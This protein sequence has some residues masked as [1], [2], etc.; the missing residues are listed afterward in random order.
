MIRD[1][2]PV[3]VQV[4]SGFIIVGKM[5]AAFGIAVAF[6]G[7]VTIARNLSPRYEHQTELGWLLIM[8]SIVIMFTTVRFWAAG[9]CG[10]VGYAALR[11]LVVVLFADAL[12]VSR[13]YIAAMSASIIAVFLLSIRFTS[14]KWKITP[15][16][17]ISIVIAAC[18]VL[19]FF[20]LSNSYQALLVFNIGS[21]ALLASRIGAR[22]ANQHQH[23]K[24]T[25]VPG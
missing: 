6:M 3:G 20:Q 9:F 15:L 12:H 24:H 19:I 21:V 8:L 18:S 2:R 1:R 7:G 10:F 11:S 17:R 4:K 14:K 23:T 25:E 5:L 16:D 13:L 22:A